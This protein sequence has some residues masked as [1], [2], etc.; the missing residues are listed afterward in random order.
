[1]CLVAADVGGRRRSA[2]VPWRVGAKP[3]SNC[4]ESRSHDMMTRVS[5]RWFEVLVRPAGGLEPHGFGPIGGIH[6]S[7]TCVKGRTRTREFVRPLTPV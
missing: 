6:A 7:E 4:L 5:R 2:A 3:E 1:M